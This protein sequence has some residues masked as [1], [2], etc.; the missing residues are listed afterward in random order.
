MVH[1]LYGGAVPAL[2]ELM[3]GQI[4]L[5]VDMATGIITQGTAG[6]VRLIGVASDRRLPAVPD[7]PIFIEQGFAGFADSTWAGMLVTSEAPQTIVKRMSDRV[8]RIIKVMKPEPGWTPLEPLPL[9]VARKSLL[10]L[11]RARPKVGRGHQRRL[12]EW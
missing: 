6:K 11:S 10:R 7:V 9:E 5:F 3:D 8:V 12:R 2:T 1:I 4:Q